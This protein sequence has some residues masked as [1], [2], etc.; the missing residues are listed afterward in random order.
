MKQLHPCAL[1]VCD[2]LNTCLY[3]YAVLCVCVCAQSDVSEQI[4]ILSGSMI[5]RWTD[6]VSVV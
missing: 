2:G 5:L 3:M 1:L 6:I 4:R